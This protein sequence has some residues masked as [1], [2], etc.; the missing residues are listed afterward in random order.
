VSYPNP[1]AHPVHLPNSSWTDLDPTEKLSFEKSVEFDSSLDAAKVPPLTHP[2]EKTYEHWAWK[3]YHH[4]WLFF[5]LETQTNVTER[6][7]FGIFHEHDP[8]DWI[9]CG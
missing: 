2:T 6:M 4:W 8:V 5:L 1:E 7:Q 3:R 9:P